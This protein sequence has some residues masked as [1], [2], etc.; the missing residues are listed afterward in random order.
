MSR[1]SEERLL[2]YVVGEQAPPSELPRS[3]QLVIGSSTEKADL[4]LSGQGVAELHCALGRAK[5]GGWALKDLGSEY[6]TIV[7]GARVTQA[8]ACAL[9][10]SLQ[11]QHKLIEVIDR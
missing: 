1:A 11:I 7:N 3:G 10:R 6:G 2:L 5:N 8:R 4:V 9:A